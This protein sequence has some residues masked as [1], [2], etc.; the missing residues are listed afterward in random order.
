MGLEWEQVVVAAADPVML[1]RWWVNERLTPGL[2]VHLRRPP[3]SADASVHRAERSPCPA[4]R[5]PPY[6]G[7]VDA[8]GGSGTAAAPARRGEPAAERHWWAGHEDA[9]PDG[10]EWLSARERARF[11]AL[12]FTKRRN[13]YLLRRWV[14]KRTVAARVGLDTGP[15]S[16]ARIE[17]LNRITGAPYVSIEGAVAPWEISLSDRAGCAVALI[18]A[19]GGGS[20]G[21]LGIDLE[22]VERRSEG[23]V[24]DFLTR[25]EQDWV[26]GAAAQDPRLGQDAAA[27]LVWSAKE[28]ALKV[29]H[30]GLRADTRW[31]EVTLASD[32]RGDGWA[33]FTAVWRGGQV[34]PGWWRR[35]GAYLLTVAAEVH[36]DPPRVLPGAVEMSLA[37]PVH[38]WVDRP[39]VTPEE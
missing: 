20:R 9:L 5:S 10:L 23:F 8:K 35:D 29:L 30:L 16:L 32:A 34:M 36:L 31:V 21:A 14:G 13:E 25:A 18:G 24:T 15:V 12:R 1:G 4:A 17:V 3:D 27:N 39:L 19:V 11:E 28:S 26:R 33:R 38:S 22:L 37:R 2:A 7:G 6:D